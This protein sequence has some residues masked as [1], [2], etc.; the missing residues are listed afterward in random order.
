MCASQLAPL[1]AMTAEEGEPKDAEQHLAAM[2]AVD[3]EDQFHD[4]KMMPAEASAEQP[5]WELA[6][7]QQSHANP[8]HQYHHDSPS[9]D[10]AWA[11]VEG[12]EWRVEEMDATDS[13]P[14]HFHRLSSQLQSLL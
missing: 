8:G 4:A 13:L 3:V 7:H 14:S 2:S 12:E 6:E 10:W 11:E 9:P 1:A 5:R